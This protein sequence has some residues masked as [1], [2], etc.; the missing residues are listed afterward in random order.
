MLSN[1]NNIY[2][3]DLELIKLANDILNW[4]KTHEPPITETNVYL[5]GRSFAELRYNVVTSTD[6]QCSESIN[7]S[8]YSTV[9][10]FIVNSG[11]HDVAV[12]LQISPDNSKFVDDSSMIVVKAGEMKVLIPMIFAKYTHLCY[13]S[14]GEGDTNLEII[15]QA[16]V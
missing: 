13:K 10:F 4:L 16:C 8:Q 5:T 3:K 11:E 6:F 12:K 15:I 9:T 14:V 1:N 7:T 2:T